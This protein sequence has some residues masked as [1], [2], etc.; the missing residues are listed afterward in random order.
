MPGSPG[1]TEAVKKD[2]TAV[3]EM[4]RTSK[5]LQSVYLNPVFSAKDKSNVI[6]GLVAEMKLTYGF[7]HGS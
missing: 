4:Y 7:A 2:L 6:N 1:E 3:A 5:N